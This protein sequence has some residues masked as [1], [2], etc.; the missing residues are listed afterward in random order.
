M[1]TGLDDDIVEMIVGSTYT[2]DNKTFDEM[3]KR[4]IEASLVQR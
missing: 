3:V 4:A 1:M 2:D